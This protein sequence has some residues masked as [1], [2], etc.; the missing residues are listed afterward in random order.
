MLIATV[1]WNKRYKYGMTFKR[2]NCTRTLLLL[3]LTLNVRSISILQEV[4]R[5]WECYSSCLPDMQ[6]QTE[7]TSFVFYTKSRL[8][9]HLQHWAELNLSGAVKIRLMIISGMFGQR[10]CFWGKAK[11]LK[12]ISLKICFKHCNWNKGIWRWA[13]GIN[14]P[15]CCRCEYW[16]SS[17]II[18][19]C[20]CWKEN[21]RI[22]K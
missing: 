15:T 12:G 1:N 6:Q 19:F 5:Q 22:P 14:V 3:F 8:W 21:S 11:W 2:Q 13:Q 10:W 9:K 7:L 4:H 20:F 18:L 17:P 16:K